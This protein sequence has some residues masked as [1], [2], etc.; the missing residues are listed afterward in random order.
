[1]VTKTRIFQHLTRMHFE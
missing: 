1:V